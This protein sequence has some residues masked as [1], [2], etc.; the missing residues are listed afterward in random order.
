MITLILKG[1][2]DS[3][4]ECELGIYLNDFNEFTKFTLTEVDVDA[5]VKGLNILGDASPDIE[6]KIEVLHPSNTTTAAAETPTEETPAKPS[7]K[8]KPK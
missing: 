6:V 4:H 5:V 7:G 1:T 8:G 2:D 3:P